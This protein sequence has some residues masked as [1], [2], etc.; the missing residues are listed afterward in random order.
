MEGLQ[1]TA[2]HA[3]YGAVKAGLIHLVRTM[4]VEWASHN[5]GVNAIAPG[6]IITARILATPERVKRTREGLIPMKRLGTS[7]EVGKAVLFLVSDLA[8]Y[9]TGHTLCVDG[10]WM[11]ASVFGIPKIPAAGVLG[12]TADA[13]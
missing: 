11:A 2:N 9:I 13:T 5:I 6:S 1:S 4:D 8:S 12:A 7:D 3:S 10:G